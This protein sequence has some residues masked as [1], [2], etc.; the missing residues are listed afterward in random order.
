M[1]ALCHQVFFFYE[2]AAGGLEREGA[3]FPSLSFPGDYQQG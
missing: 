1:R 2:A 3:F